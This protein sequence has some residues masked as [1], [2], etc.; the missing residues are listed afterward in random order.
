MDWPK[1]IEINRD[2]LTRIVAGLVALLVAQGGAVRLPR[3]VYQLLS[4]ILY[5]AESAVRRL[6][7]IAARGLVVRD[8]PSRPMTPG[9]V[10][11]GTAAG[12]MSFQLFDTRKHFGDPDDVPTA[13]SGPRIRSIDV[14]S[15]RQLFLNKFAKPRD[16]RCSEAETI[17]ITQRLNLLSRAL[18]DLPRE[19]KRMARWLKRHA[20]MERPGLIFPLR[21]GPPPGHQQ[22]PREDIDSVLRE[23]HALAWMALSPD[24]S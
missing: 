2:A 1:A 7:V 19:A 21:P 3:V 12:R 17:R 24:T 4:R 16:D 13:I 20:V 18:D 23:C 8:P 5:P 14:L 15:P 10:I 6:I 22:R 11:A 9:L